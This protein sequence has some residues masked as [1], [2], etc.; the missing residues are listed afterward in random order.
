MDLLKYIIVAIGAVL[1]G[2]ILSILVRN[3]FAG[4]GFAV[5]SLG[6]YILWNFF[7]SAK[8][9]SPDDSSQNTPT[10]NS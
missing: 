1:V 2:I 5:L 4:I 10:Q 7:N 3:I 6:G 8:E 9:V